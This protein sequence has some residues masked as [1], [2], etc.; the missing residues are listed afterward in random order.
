LALLAVL[1]AALSG[2]V[3]PAAQASQTTPA[4]QHGAA[5]AN[6]PQA[7][8]DD[9]GRQNADCGYYVGMFNAEELDDAKHPMFSNKINIALDAI[10]GAV[11]YGHSVVAGNSR[12]FYGSITPASAGQF[13]IVAHEPGDDQ[14]DGVFT[15][16]LDSAQHTLS[17]TWLANSKRLAVTK[18]SYE[19]TRMAF[20]YDPALALEPMEVELYSK[21]RDE[22]DTHRGEAVTEDAAK[23]NASV[24]PLKSKDVENLYKRDLEVMRNAIY[25]RH[26]YSFQNR[27]MRDFFDNYVDW[28]IPVS[29]DITAE[30]TDVEQQNIAL[31]KRYEQHADSYYDHFGR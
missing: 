21:R 4:G 16:T 29:T 27:Q 14:Y 26:G 5:T 30:L 1:A 19:L 6:F 24:Q 15:A 3:Q 10:D 13:Q 23:F 28:Y 11:L 22:G 18:R 8:P 25:A 9:P 7:A 12:P 31:L 17:G 2:C 20:K